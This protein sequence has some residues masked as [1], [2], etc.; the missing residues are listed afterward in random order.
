MACRVTLKAAAD[1]GTNIYT[2]MEIS[3]GS[4]T[5]P[6]IRPAFPTGTSAA[7]IRA[8]MQV[9]ATNQP[10]LAA[11]IQALVNSSVTA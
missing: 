4:R 10:T 11:D 2:E 1:D 3:D 7:T 8:Y 6:L 9:I 5:F